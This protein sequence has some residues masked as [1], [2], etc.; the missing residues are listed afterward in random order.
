MPFQPGPVS[1]AILPVCMPLSHLPGVSNLYELT[2]FSI[3]NQEKIDRL[4][5]IRDYG[6]PRPSILLIYRSR[7]SGSWLSTGTLFAKQTGEEM[8]GQ[9]RPLR[10]YRF[11]EGWYT[12]SILQPLNV[13]IKN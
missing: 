9:F 4:P 12:E 5:D 8:N 1:K 3:Q 6:N 13:L 2:N 7:R 11:F 10:E